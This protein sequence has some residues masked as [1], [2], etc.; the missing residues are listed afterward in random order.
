MRITPEKVDNFLVVVDLVWAQGYFEGSLDLLDAFDVGDG[1]ADAAVA[2][3]DS[4]LLI[5]N[6]SRQRQIVKSIVD[7]GKAAVCICDV[8]V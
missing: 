4:L 2:A 5:R 6:N 3:E 7:F 8:L 1:G